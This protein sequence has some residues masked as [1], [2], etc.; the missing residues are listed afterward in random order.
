ME[1]R[2]E[3]P[4]KVYL[5]RYRALVIRQESIRRAI[6]AAYDQATS[7]TSRLRAVPVSGGGAGDRMAEDV[8][9]IMD[10][11]AQ[12]EQLLDASA[13]ALSEIL[14]AIDAVPDEMQRTVLVLRYV[15]GLDW[16]SISERIHYEERQTFI[17]H[18]RALWE[19]RRWLEQHPETAQEN[20][21]EKML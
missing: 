13:Q 8:A 2:A 19:V 18:G 1:H 10:E 5:R 21:V 11:A 3:N 4:A 17:I 6:D 9:R 16:I 15:E 20:A 14:R 12:L 7:I